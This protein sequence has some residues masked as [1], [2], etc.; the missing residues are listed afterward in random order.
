MPIVR[1]TTSAVGNAIVNQV[2]GFILD[3]ADA[4]ENDTEVTPEDG[5]DALGHAIA[6]GISMALASAPIKGAFAA[7]ICPP[8]GDVVPLNATGDKIFKVLESVAKE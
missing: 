3:N 7:G 6:Y 8:G 4:M 5:A 1:R 2:K